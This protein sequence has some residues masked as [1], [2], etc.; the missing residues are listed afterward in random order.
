M[1]FEIDGQ[2]GLVRDAHSKAVIST[3][4]SALMKNREAHKA[5]LER[6]AKEQS[7]D[8]EINTL[9]S[10]VSEIRKEIQELKSLLIEALKR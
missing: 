6:I 2:K 4:R 3:D 5:A 7:R 10:D 1:Y 9:K 8:V